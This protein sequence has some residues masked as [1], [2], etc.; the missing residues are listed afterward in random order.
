MEEYR[1]KVCNDANDDAIRKEILELAE[2]LFEGI[3]AANSYWSL[4]QN[5]K[6]YA[7]DFL[8]EINYSPAFYSTVYLSLSESLYMSLSKLYDWNG[9]AKSLRKLLNR[10]GCIQEEM[11]D[12]HVRETYIHDGRVFKHSLSA[13]EEPFFPEQ[14]KWVKQFHEEH[15]RKHRSIRIEL[16]LPKLIGLYKDRFES[17]KDRHIICNLLERRN[18]IFAHNDKKVNFDIQ[19]VLKEFPLSAADI[20]ELI[21]YAVDIL[22]FCIE[23]LSGVCKQVEYV[24]INDLRAT[25]EAVRFHK[26]HM[27][28]A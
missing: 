28:E 1:P 7:N 12:S 25:L 14:V 24:N 15:E 3:C 8:D 22:Q 2:N 20:Q 6:E 9:D 26:T 4:L 5:F 18:K 13:Y 27:D 21:D 11:F 16:S 10:I 17:M 19:V 23:I